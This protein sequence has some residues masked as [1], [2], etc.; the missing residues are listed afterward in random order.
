MCQ[1]FFPLPLQF[2]AP[3]FSLT[4]SETGQEM[5]ARYDREQLAEN[6]SQCT[7]AMIRDF[8]N[9]QTLLFPPLCVSRTSN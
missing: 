5:E 9:G 6:G 3:I 8:A 2:L 1:V 7:M 4:E